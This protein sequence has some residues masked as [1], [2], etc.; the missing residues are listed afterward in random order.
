VVSDDHFGRGIEFHSLT[1][2]RVFR[3][4]LSSFSQVVQTKH[5]VLRRNGDGRAVGRVEDVVRRQHQDRRFEDRL[6]TERNVYRHL[7]T[8]EVGVKRRTYERVKLNSLTFNQLGL[9]GLDTETVQRRSTVE[10]YRVTLEYVFKDIPDHRIL[11]VDD[12]LR[13]LHRLHDSSFNELADDE[14]LKELSRHIL[15]QTAFVQFEFRTDH[16]NGTTGVVDTL[17]EKVLTEASLLTFEH[18]A[19]RFQGAVSIGT[20]GV[21]LS[22]VVEQRVDSFL[23]HPLFVAEDHFGSF[24]IDQSLETVVADDNPAVQVVQVR[25]CKA[26]AIQRNERTQLGRNHRHHLD[27]HPLR[28]ILDA[29]AC[30]AERFNH[31]KA[32]ER[33]CFALLRH[34]GSS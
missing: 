8:V 2:N 17:T 30:F 1:R 4:A 9:E 25:R 20:H 3:R 11:T 16:D 22:R 12:L 18:V 29:R 14:R 28:T 27:D 13:R 6:L 24:D 5:H 21:H 33:F 34:V 10:Q 19:Q 32:L 23:K 31:L 15:G 26:A 7:V